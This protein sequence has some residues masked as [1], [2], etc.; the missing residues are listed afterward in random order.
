MRS[1]HGEETTTVDWVVG[2][3]G[4]HSTVRSLVGTALVGSF[5]GQHFVFADVDGETNLPKDALHMFA[6]RDGIAALFPMAGDRVRLLFEVPAPAPGTEPTLDD[7]QRLVDE[8]LGSRLQVGSSHWL[9]YFEVHHG[10]VPRYRFDR[11]LL[12]GDAAHIHS[13]AGGQGMNTGMQ[14]A[15]N[16]AWKLALVAQRRADPS[17]LDSYETE[18]YPIAASVVR[19]TT[20]MTAAMTAHGVAGVIRGWALFAAG[21]TS[22]ITDAAAARLAE[23]TV[24]YPHSAIVGHAYSHHTRALHP[25]AHAPEVPGLQGPDGDPVAIGDL[26]QQP[27]HLVLARSHDL[28]LIT[29]LVNAL[30]DLGTV[31]HVVDDRGQNGAVPNSLVD[32]GGELAK[33]Y[34]LGDDGFVAIR[35]DGY[36]GFLATPA[37]PGALHRYLGEHL[38]VS[39]G[40]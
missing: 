40:H 17:L 34:G 18:R 38:A 20:A 1:D 19:M 29:G 14:D 4:A 11:V 9:T 15:A 22:T 13:P 35:P 39:A 16:L 6:H 21:H 28:D 8:R 31:F 37:D 32:P 7:V 36:I 30:G 2:S 25:G 24:G 5:H 26:L 23:L 12:A 27:G 3:D 10:Q 33:A